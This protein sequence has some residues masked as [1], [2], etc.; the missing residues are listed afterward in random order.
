MDA[1][2]GRPPPA[3][4]P[5]IAADAKQ[6]KGQGADVGKVYNPLEWFTKLRGM[7]ANARASYWKNLIPRLQTNAAGEITDAVITCNLCN[8]DFASTNVHQLAGTHFGGGPKACV[9]GRS[10]KRSSSGD[11]AGPSTSEAGEESDK[12]R[13]TSDP[14]EGVGR[15][16][17]LIGFGIPAATIAKAM[18]HLCRFFY[19]S[20]VALQLVEHPDL[21]KC[22]GLLNIQTPNRR[23]AMVCAVPS[24]CVC[25]TGCTASDGMTISCTGKHNLGTLSGRWGCLHTV[26]TKLDAWMHVEHRQCL[27]QHLAPVGGQIWWLLQVSEAPIIP[28][29]MQ[30]EVLWAIRPH[31]WPF[32][33]SK[34]ATWLLIL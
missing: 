13:R 16:S 18:K 20:N 14:G 2:F 6:F 27:L 3:P 19:T 31:T 10:L 32:P 4:K 24:A 23:L 22:F 17:S 34:W 7:Q 25:S 33:V 9:Y 26:H 1:F 11:D 12:K 28:G 29:M 15:P 8:T 21:V 5:K 30:S